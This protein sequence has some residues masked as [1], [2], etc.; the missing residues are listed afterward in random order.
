[1]MMMMM[2][3]QA[4]MAELAALRDQIRERDVELDKLSEPSTVAPAP[5]PPQ[6]PVD[7]EAEVRH[8]FF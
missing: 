5:A 4:T 8:V 3:E 7:E 6:P 2:C 1:M